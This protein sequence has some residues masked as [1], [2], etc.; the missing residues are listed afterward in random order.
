MSD[1]PAE[2]GSRIVHTAWTVYQ[3]M[4]PPDLVDEQRQYLRRSFYAGSAVMF[5]TVAALSALEPADADG[6]L[7]AISQELQ[8]YLASLGS[9]LEGRV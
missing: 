9:V 3:G 4:L 5:S 2:I 7:S 1:T 6:V 8:V